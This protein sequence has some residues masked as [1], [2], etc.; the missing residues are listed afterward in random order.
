MRC[1]CPCAGSVNSSADIKVNEEVGRMETILAL[2]QFLL[3]QVDDTTWERIQHGGLQ[4]VEKNYFE[5]RDECEE[6]GVVKR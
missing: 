6:R 2:E 3:Q 1:S 5:S 4:L